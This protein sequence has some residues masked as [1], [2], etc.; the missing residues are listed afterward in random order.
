MNQISIL[1]TAPLPGVDFT[2]NLPWCKYTICLERLNPIPEPPSRVEKKG[3]KILSIL[4]GHK[5]HRQP[6]LENYFPINYNSKIL[7]SSKAANFL[8]DGLGA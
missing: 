5:V 6:I 7:L 4:S 2:F 1:K 8:S 3:M